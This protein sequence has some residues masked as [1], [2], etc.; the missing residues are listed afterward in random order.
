MT[1]MET[2]TGPGRELLSI[3]FLYSKSMACLEIHDADYASAG[4]FWNLLIRWPPKELAPMCRG[5]KDV[6]ESFRE[7]RL[8]E[9]PGAP[10]TCNNKPIFP[11]NICQQCQNCHAFGSRGVA[12][13]AELSVFSSEN[14]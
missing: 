4:S 9:H 5:R 1:E 2:Q 3:P 6:S 11:V 12:D 10:I 14:D 7:L 8:R 13:L